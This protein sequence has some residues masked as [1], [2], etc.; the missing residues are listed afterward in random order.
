MWNRTLVSVFVFLTVLGAMIGVLVAKIFSNPV[1]DPRMVLLA[2][3]PR[4]NEADLVGTESSVSSQSR[5]PVPLKCWCPHDPPQQ[6]KQQWQWPS[7]PIC[8]ACDDNDANLFSAWSIQVHDDIQLSAT[9]TPTYFSAQRAYVRVWM[10]MKSQFVRERMTYGCYASL[11]HYVCENSLLSTF[12]LE[13][14]TGGTFLF[15]T[16]RPGEEFAPECQ[17]WHDQ[18][19]YWLNHARASKMI[20]WTTETVLEMRKATLSRLPILFQQCAWL[21]QS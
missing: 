6:H 17:R 4:G 10:G 9:N 20:G 14:K 8:V 13:I 2:L 18:T 1:I 3:M 7:D 11:W 12:L 19:R 21:D 16:D 15:H 5:L